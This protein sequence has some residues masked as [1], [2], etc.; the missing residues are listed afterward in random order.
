MYQLING[1]EISHVLSGS[2][3]DVSVT[4]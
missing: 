1:G 4:N 2:R 3:R